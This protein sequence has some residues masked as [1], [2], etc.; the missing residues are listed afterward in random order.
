MNYP[1][2][3]PESAR[4]YE[5]AKVVMP[6]GNTRTTVYFDPFPIYAVRGEGCRMWDA[7]GHVY[8]DCINNFTSMI[9]GYAAPSINAVVSAQLALGTAFGAPTSSEIDLAELL[10]ARLPAVDQVRFT[11]SGTEAV[12]MA[13]KAARAFTGR[14]KIAKIEGAYHGSYDYA[15]VS[16]D[17]RPDN[18]SNTPAS[19]AYAEGTPQ[20][21]LDDV[22]VLPLNDVAT[23]QAVIAEHGPQLAA[24]LIDPLPNRAGLIPARR[25]YLTA[26]SKA[27]RA[28]GVLLILDE[29]IS[30]RL[31]YSGAQGQWEIAPDLT[32]LGKIIGG[33]F[34]VGAVGG[35]AD[36]MS[37]FDPTR[38]KPALP[39]GGTFSA[40]PVTMRAG[41]A[42]MQALTPAVFERLNS[43]GETAR[44]GVNAS[45][46]RHGLA[47]V[48]VGLGSLFKVHF[49]DQP[50]TDYRSVYPNAE[51]RRKLGNFHMALLNRGILAAGYG[52]FALSTPMTDSDVTEIIK[53]ID[54]ALAEVAA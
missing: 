13:I 23:A 53:A 37:V 2:T 10:V 40:N 9:H 22:V 7:D 33:G 11:N 42:S 35:R 14:P 17:S 3:S 39:H 34:P 25:D 16:L 20:G 32:V 50:V 52:L 24:I 41:L 21:V 49:T 12:M 6:G 27:A 44:Q 45:F 38:G 1:E 46:A 28:A 43:I 31:G 30:F 48:C 4:L 18:W 51:A 15:E 36:V 8:I 54:E 5:R 26:L 19:I 29:V 47:G